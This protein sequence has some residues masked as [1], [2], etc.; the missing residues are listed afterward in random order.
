MT[1]SLTPN[2]ISI[3]HKEVYAVRMERKMDKTIDYPIL[4]KKIVKILHK[5]GQ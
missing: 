3:H 5:E 2:L 1:V 4:L